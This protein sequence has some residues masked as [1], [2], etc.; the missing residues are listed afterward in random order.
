MNNRPHITFYLLALWMLASCRSTSEVASTAT[1]APTLAPSPAATLSVPAVKE[2]TATNS[3]APSP[4]PT[5]PLDTPTTSPPTP[6]ATPDYPVYRGLPIGRGD[7]GVQIHLH[8]EDQ[9]LI[10]DQLQDLGVGWVKVQVSWK[11][12]Q[13]EPDRFDDFRFEELDRFIEAAA[14]ND[15]DVLLSVAKA[16]EWSRPTTELD[17]PPS[18]YAHF[19]A[20]MRTLAS[21]YLG[22]VGAYELWNEPNLQREWNGAP[23]GGF[24]VVDLIRAGAAGV[25]AVDPAA[26]IISGAPAP[27]GINDGVTAIDD[28]LF[29]RQMV[30]AGLGDVVDAVG[31]HPYGW[32]NPPD[33]S[34]AAPD[35]AV[36]SHNNHP[37]FFFGDTLRDYRAILELA[38]LGRLPLWATE[39]GWGSYDGLGV[40][41]PAG[42]AYMGAVDE[43]Q[44]AAYTLRA[45]EMA[46]D[47]EWVGPLFL[48]NLNFGPTFG[49]DFV[50]S[51]YSVLRPD[52]SPRPL[53]HSLATVTE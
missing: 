45:Y 5:E 41:P 3:P 51:S 18:D 23:L 53:F 36:P 27:T 6:T 33:S 34:A 29:L 50:E 31:V 17:G 47:W 52:G 16:P 20:F 42:V 44:Q 4:R 43:Q 24:P 40:S 12:Y 30:D 19:E 1:S 21:R 37:S 10:V 15:I 13:P 25:R 48:W 39:F 2:S 38:A 26:I 7:V 35:P 9:A 46:R 28:R 22:R 49:T 14:A 8:R 32:A 11:I